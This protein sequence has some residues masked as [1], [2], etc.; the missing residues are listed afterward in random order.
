MPNPYS[1]RNWWITLD[2]PP[3]PLHDSDWHFEHNDFDGAP[4]SHDWRYGH[5][6]S[7]LEAIRKIDEREADR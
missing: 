4:D 6:P 7:L 1:Y 2:P 5:A 3:I